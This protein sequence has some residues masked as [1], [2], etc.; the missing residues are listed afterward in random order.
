MRRARRPERAVAVVSLPAMLGRW[1]VS[2]GLDF[3]GM[4]VGGYMKR[5]EF[6]MISSCLSSNF[7]ACLR[8][9]Q[10][11]SRCSMLVA[12]RRLLLSEYFLLS[13][14]YCIFVYVSLAFQ[15]FPACESSD[16]STHSPYLG[17]YS[18]ETVVAKSPFPQSC[19]YPES[20]PH[21]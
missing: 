21:P 9:Y 19:A 16:N 12:W 6:A 2:V 13:R 8:M 17:I 20:K 10:M 14:W 1:G 11:K 3:G 5:P 18:A 15:P 7:S 4:E